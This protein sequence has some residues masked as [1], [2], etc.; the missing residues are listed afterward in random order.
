MNPSEIIENFP[1][2][3]DNL[4]LI[5]H[6]LQDGHPKNYLTQEALEATA[7]HLKLT[8][9]AVYGVAGYY[10][11]FSLNPRGQHIIRVCVSPVC[12]LMKSNGIISALE[13]VLEIKVGETTSD[14]LFTLEA[15]ECLGQCQEAPAMMIGQKVY[16]SLDKEKI[17]A[18]IQLYRQP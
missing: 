1:P 17:E 12:E 10:S 15:A 18:I 16:A 7:R 8:K 14:A 5:L 3:Q 6:A 4:L 11:M 2:T 9:S 13:S